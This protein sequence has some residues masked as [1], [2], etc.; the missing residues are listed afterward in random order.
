MIFILSSIPGSALPPGR[1]STLGHF[2]LYF[3]LGALVFA[4]LDGDLRSRALSA[5]AIASA[6]GVSDELH[7]LFVPGRCA[8]PIDWLVDTLGALTAIVLILFILRPRAS[9]RKD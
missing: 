2:T 6:Y 3:V 7:Q 4:A 5:I 8:D 1:Y 9:R